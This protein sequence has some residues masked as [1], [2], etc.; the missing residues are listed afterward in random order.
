[1]RRLQSSISFPTMRIVRTKK[2]A[3][4]SAAAQAPSQRGLRIESRS[5]SL[6]GSEFEFEAGRAGRKPDYCSV[7]CRTASLDLARLISSLPA[8]AS[9][10]PQAASLIRRSVGSLLNVAINPAVAE[11]NRAERLR[12]AGQHGS[13]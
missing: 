12:E 2:T 3:A 8:V 5:C 4:A 9:M 10:T 6:C 7:E 11:H 1:M 13:E